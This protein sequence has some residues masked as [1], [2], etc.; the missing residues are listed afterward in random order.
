MGAVHGDG[1]VATVAVLVGTAATKSAWDADNG[2]VAALGKLG[3]GC[4]GVV[5]ALAQGVAEEDAVLQAL[6]VCCTEGEGKEG[7]EEVKGRNEKAG[8]KT[9]PHTETPQHHITHT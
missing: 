4:D 9:P 5:K 1:L 2:T 6:L 7:K 3:D 8:A